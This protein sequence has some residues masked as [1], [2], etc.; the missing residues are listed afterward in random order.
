MIWIRHHDAH[1][2]LLEIAAGPSPGAERA[3]CDV[4][5]NTS[6]HRGFWVDPSGEPVALVATA[7]GPVLLVD[8]RRLVLRCGSWTARTAPI[9]GPR[10][11]FELNVEGESPVV[12]EY[13]EPPSHYG[14]WSDDA[15]VDFFRWLTTKVDNERFHTW[16]TVPLP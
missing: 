3:A 15:F 9:E 11:L 4:P 1:A 6:L 13:E 10:R 7:D 12:L 16:W 8:G 5:A 2:R 14:G